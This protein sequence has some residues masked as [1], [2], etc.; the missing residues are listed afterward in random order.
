[1]AADICCAHTQTP[2][3]YYSIHSQTH[4]Y[5]L[6]TEATLVARR[7]LFGWREWDFSS[8]IQDLANTFIALVSR[9]IRGLYGA[10]GGQ[11]A[12][13]R[14]A[15]EAN[16]AVTLIASIQRRTTNGQKQEEKSDARNTTTTTR[17]DDT[18]FCWLMFALTT[19]AVCLLEVLLLRVCSCALGPATAMLQK[20]RRHR[21]TILRCDCECWRAVSEHVFCELSQK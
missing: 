11:A 16:A 20:T 18:T 15:H 3:T 7:T 5:T 14:I 9:P 1:M 21:Q 19:F 2:Q 6:R 8:S 4:L 13:E 17:L 12:D 10:V